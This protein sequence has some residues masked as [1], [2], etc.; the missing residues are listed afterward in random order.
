MA[1]KPVLF[2]EDADAEYQEAVD[3]YVVR[4]PHAASEFA[5]ELSRAVELIA[6]APHRWASSHDSRQA[7][8]SLALLIGSLSQRPYQKV[9]KRV[10][11][12]RLI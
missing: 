9:I 2:H 12:N 5:E 8:N 6:Q 11:P 1:V 3:W 10:S 7:I 4:S